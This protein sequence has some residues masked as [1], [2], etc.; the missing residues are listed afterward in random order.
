M[1]TIIRGYRGYI[2]GLYRD[3]GQENVDCEKIICQRAYIGHILCRT[4][5]WAQYNTLR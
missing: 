5:L 1:E 3:K 2:L 4:G